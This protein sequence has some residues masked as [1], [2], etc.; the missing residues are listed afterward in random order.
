MN[1]TKTTPTTTPTY[2]AEPADY[3]KALKFGFKPINA[4]MAALIEAKI[5]DR[6]MLDA[7]GAYNRETQRYAKNNADVVNTATW[8][9]ARRFAEY[10][11]GRSLTDSER[12]AFD[13]VRAIAER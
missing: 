12:D 10:T 1:E 7:C 5:G 8:G 3:I 2:S 11:I 9:S 6:A 4:M 13:A